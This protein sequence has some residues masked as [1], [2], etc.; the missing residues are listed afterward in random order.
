MDGVKITGLWKNTGKDGKT[1]LSGSV[2]GVKVLVF[3]NAYK[4]AEGDP[5]YNLFVS[6]SEKKKPAEA[7]S[8]S[9]DL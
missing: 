1:F 9:G 3:P 8:P 2:G 7:S 6:Q 5:D 4:K